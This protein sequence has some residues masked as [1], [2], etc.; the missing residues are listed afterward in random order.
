MPLS[1]WIVILVRVAMT[2]HPADNYLRAKVLTATPEQLQLLLFDGAIRFCDQA[3]VAIVARKFDDS[4]NLISKAQKIVTELIVSL[5]HDAYPDLCKKLS[6]LYTFAYGKLME[7]NINHDLPSL[8]EGLNVLR[9]QRETWA[10]LMEKLQK[11]KAAKAAQNIALP[12]PSQRM[13]A[14]ISMQG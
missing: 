5:K 10:M 3:R 11:D 6:A 4:Y 14:S 7:A 12:E 1:N 8:D 13:E 9:Y 2:K